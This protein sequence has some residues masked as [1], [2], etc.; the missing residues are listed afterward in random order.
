MDI[1]VSTNMNW[2]E[3]EGSVKVSGNKRTLEEILAMWKDSDIEGYIKVGEKEYAKMCQDST[4][5]SR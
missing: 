3:V 1:S 2:F 5:A 4:E